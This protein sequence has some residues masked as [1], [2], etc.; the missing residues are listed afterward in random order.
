MDKANGKQCTFT[1]PNQT[2]KQ[3]LQ[4]SFKEALVL[5]NEESDN[6]EESGLVLGGHSRNIAFF[7][8]LHSHYFFLLTADTSRDEALVAWLSD[9]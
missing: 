9:G 5:D 4:R 7:C 8:F 3:V 6:E 2:E 1:K